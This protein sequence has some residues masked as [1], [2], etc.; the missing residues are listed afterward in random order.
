M[1]KKILCLVASMLFA[2]NCVMQAQNDNDNDGDDDEITV[3]DNK[4][5]EEVIEFPEAMT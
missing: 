2:G 4:G 5:N 1:N 3:T